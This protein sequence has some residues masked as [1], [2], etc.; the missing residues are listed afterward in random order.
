[1]TTIK[2]REKLT[3]NTLKIP[4]QS[5]HTFIKNYYR[6]TND[7]TLLC[8]DNWM[9]IWTYSSTSQDE[10]QLKETQHHHHEDTL[11]EHYKE[12]KRRRQTGLQ[13]A[14]KLP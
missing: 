3:V 6:E 5:D 4:S 14:A 9:K 11:N 1:M 8:V 12:T 7:E 13:R 2:E 10:T